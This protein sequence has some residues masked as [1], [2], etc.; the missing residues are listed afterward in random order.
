VY[1]ISTIGYWALIRQDNTLPCA[2]HE[3]HSQ[4]T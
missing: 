1:A 3:P 4:H 2:Q